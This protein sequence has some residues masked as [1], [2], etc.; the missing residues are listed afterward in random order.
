MHKGVNNRKN[1]GYSALSKIYHELE[2]NNFFINKFKTRNVSEF[3]IN[4]IMKLLVFSRALFP[5][6]KKSTFENKDMFFENTNFSLQEV[7]L[8]TYSGTVLS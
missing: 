1:F 2:I 4:N 5:D 8:W 3:K 7:Y 6:S